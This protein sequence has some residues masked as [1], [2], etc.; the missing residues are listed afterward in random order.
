MTPSYLA[1]FNLLI[2][3][4]FNIS[5]LNST[6]LTKEASWILKVADKQNATI[7]MLFK[8]VLQHLCLV[9]DFSPSL[10]DGLESK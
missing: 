4:L 1:I 10:V 8:L 6:L 2:F 5:L 3:T 7:S 9:I